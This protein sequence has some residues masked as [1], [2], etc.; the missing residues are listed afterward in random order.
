MVVINRRGYG[1]GG[2]VTRN[3]TT[4]SCYALTWVTRWTRSTIHDAGS[5]PGRRHLP[6]AVVKRATVL[7][8]SS[9]GALV[10]IQITTLTLSSAV[11]TVENR[12]CDPRSRV[13]PTRRRPTTAVHKR[14]SGSRGPPAAWS[15]LKRFSVVSRIALYTVSRNDRLAQ[16]APAP[17]RL[18]L[19]RLLPHL[20]QVTSYS[21]CRRGVSHQYHDPWYLHS[22]RHPRESSGPVHHGPRHRKSSDCKGNEAVTHRLG[23]HPTRAER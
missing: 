17:C 15:G 9:R 1:R 23:H 3:L 18:A 12:P 8:T 6:P 2:H 13:I 19:R 11:T 4:A 21:R 16:M 14:R 7:S 5:H 20:H 10:R 22:R